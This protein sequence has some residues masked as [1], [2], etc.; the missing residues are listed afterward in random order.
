ML[1]RGRLG[2]RVEGQDGLLQIRPGHASGVGG[3]G[4]RAGRA[5]GGG[6]LGAAEEI[7]PKQRIAWSLR[8]GGSLGRWL[9]LSRCSSGCR[10]CRT[11]A[12]RRRNVI[13]KQI[14]GG[15]LPLGCGGLARG[16]HS[17]RSRA[18]EFR[19]LLDDRKGL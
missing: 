3:C 1:R 6:R 5:T 9:L 15:L 2:L 10:F 18:L 17:L 13:T 12:H 19:L 16:G 7:Q 4:R 8:L 14:D 11:G